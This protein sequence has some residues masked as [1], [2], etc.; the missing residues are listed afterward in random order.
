[1][2]MPDAQSLKPVLMSHLSLQ[3]SCTS[4]TGGL[5]APLVVTLR[6]VQP[7]SWHECHQRPVWLHYIECIGHTA[8]HTYPCTLAITLSY[9]CTGTQA[10]TR[11]HTVRSGVQVPWC[12]SISMDSHS[13]FHAEGAHELIRMPPP[14]DPTPWC[15]AL[16]P[17]SSVEPWVLSYR[18]PPGLQPRPP[19]W[20]E[21]EGDDLPLCDAGLGGGAHHAG[22]Q[23]QD[24]AHPPGGATWPGLQVWLHDQA[25]AG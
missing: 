9:P 18:L 17:Q 19:H 7:P 10:R 5:T 1:M 21:Q 22:G 12:T 23:A 11:P 3:G 14:P 16:G 8:P 13:P 24:D 6:E 15:L 20:A 4:P 25:G 2:W